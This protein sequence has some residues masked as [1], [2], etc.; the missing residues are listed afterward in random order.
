MKCQKIIWPYKAQNSL[1][2]NIIAV[3]SP[4]VMTKFELRFPCTHL[5][6]RGTTCGYNQLRSN[7]SRL[8]TYEKICV[9]AVRC[10]SLSN[11]YRQICIYLSHACVFV[12][13]VLVQWLLKLSI[14]GPGRCEEFGRIYLRR[15]EIARRVQF[16]TCEHVTIVAGRRLT[17]PGKPQ[18]MS[19]WVT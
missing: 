5:R 17:W 8:N 4:K 7:N 9:N 6:V 15:E 1:Y 2:N 11:L 18:K 16:A 3:I 10:L 13:R 19:V 12:V 14:H